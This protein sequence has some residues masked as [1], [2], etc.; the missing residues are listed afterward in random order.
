M[1]ATISTLH[2]PKGIHYEGMHHDPL[3]QRLVWV[4]ILGK[5][6]CLL[7][8]KTDSF[9]AYDMPSM[10]GFALPQGKDEFL[11]GLETGLALY[12]TTTQ[13]CTT[14]GDPEPQYPNSRFNDGKSDPLGRIWA[15]TMDIDA[16]HPVGH[17]YRCDLNQTAPASYQS[18]D[19]GFTIGNGPTWSAD[20][21]IL[22]HA[23][24]CK[25]CVFAFDF[26]LEKGTIHNKRLFYD[27][28]DKSMAPDGM[29]TDSA[30]NLWI[31][32]AHG[33]QVIKVS[34]EGKLVDQ[35]ALPT[36][37]PTSLASIDDDYRCLYI[38][39]S[40]LDDIAGDELAGCI[41]KAEC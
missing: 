3:Y 13:Q 28:Q 24:T 25:G 11:C 4:D 6:L 41:L 33:S 29:Q 35:I 18:V 36:T 27:H 12:N 10:I 39:T 5:T 7:D 14:L 26:D 32:M 21:R 22:Y 20:G 34:P 38:T 1:D 17:L 8:M 37:F 16:N 2:I 23:E 30:G 31:A 19:S 40:Q 15:N 9:S